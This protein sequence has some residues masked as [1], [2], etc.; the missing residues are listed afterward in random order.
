MPELCSFINVVGW[1]EKRHLRDDVITQDS[2]LL[3][4]V[5]LNL[6]LIAPHQICP[7]T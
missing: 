4:D 5:N 3:C 7:V 1:D 2:L 6:H